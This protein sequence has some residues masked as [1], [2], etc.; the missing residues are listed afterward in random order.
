MISRSHSESNSH[1][2][3]FLYSETKFFHQCCLND[4]LRRTKRRGLR[5]NERNHH[6]DVS[7]SNLTGPAYHH[8][9]H[10]P[11]ISISHCSLAVCR[12]CCWPAGIM[13]E[14]FVIVTQGEWIHHSGQKQLNCSPGDEG[15]IM[16]S[17][18][19]LYKLECVINAPVTSQL[20]SL[21]EV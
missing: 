1:F 13:T 16:D 2:S 21:C 7:W 18:R 6:I 19:G 11:L 10:G 5:S 15:G 9:Q 8:Y 3:C 12:C 17:V 20:S 14:P 4:I